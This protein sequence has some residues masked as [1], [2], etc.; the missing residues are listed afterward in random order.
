MTEMLARRTHSTMASWNIMHA[1]N[2]HLARLRKYSGSVN[3]V[4]S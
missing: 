3:N 1:D 2:V 4:G